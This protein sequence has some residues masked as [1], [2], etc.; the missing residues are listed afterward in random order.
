MSTKPSEPKTTSLL[1]WILTALLLSPFL[2]CTVFIV[3]KLVGTVEWGW[4]AVFSPLLGLLGLFFLVAALFPVEGEPKFDG[5][6]PEEARA[7][8]KDAYVKRQSNSARSWV[9]VSWIFG[10]FWHWIFGETDGSP[11]WWQIVYWTVQVG[12]IIL[13]IYLFWSRMKSIDAKYG[14]EITVPPAPPPS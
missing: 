11:L 13:G 6:P 5:L 12:S 2:T 7:K 4:F 10:G 8:E 14:K 1:G 9:A 3:L